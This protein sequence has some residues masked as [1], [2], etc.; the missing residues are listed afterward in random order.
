V[1]DRRAPPIPRPGCRALDPEGLI[2]PYHLPMSASAVPAAGQAANRA[3]ETAIA[4]PRLES[5]DVVR[6]VVM[7]VM[8]L[9]H[10]RD[11]FSNA[12]LNFFLASELLKAPAALFFTRWV[13]HFCAPVFVFLAGTGAYFGRR[14]RTPAQMSWFLLTRGIWLVVLELTIVH[15]CWT[16][17]LHLQNT[18]V[19]VIWAIGWSMV[20]LAVLVFLPTWLVGAFGVAMIAVHNAF[21]SVKPEAFAAGPSLWAILHV[22]TQAQ[23]V[24][25]WSMFVAYPLVPWIGVMAAGYAFGALFMLPAEPRRKTLAWIG[26]A[27]VLV[28]V[29]LR[30]SNAYGDPLPWSFQPQHGIHTLISFL[31]TEKYPPSLLY[32]L[33]TLGPAILAL[34]LLDGR[35][36]KGL[37]RP[38][39]VFGRVPLFYYLLHILVLHLFAAFYAFGKYGSKAFTL[40]PLNLPPDYGLSLPAVYAIWLGTVA[41]LYTPCAWYARVKARSTNPLFSYL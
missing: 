2:A 20:V 7:V 32:L 10:T 18:F 9:D 11:Y 25:G 14:R 34:A 16:F 27:A 12:R 24:P 3:A 35:P 33:M 5:V 13:T 37:A 28:F 38:L 19:Q 29:G 30:F 15:F 21:D 31:D 8:A 36:A 39:V 22:P 23:I 4:R 40:D 26:T 6:G 17:D 1:D 41:L